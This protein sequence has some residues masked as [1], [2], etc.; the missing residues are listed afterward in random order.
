MKRELG[1]ITGTADLVIEPQV[2]RFAARAYLGAAAGVLALSVAALVGVRE[3]ARIEPMLAAEGQQ[4]RRAVLYE[5]TVGSELRVP[6]EPRTDVLRFVVHAYRRAGDMPLT[7]RKA[8]LSVAVNGERRSRV[9]ELEAYPPGLRSRVTAEDPKLEVGDPM[10]VE[11]DVHDAGVGE[12]VVKLKSI[13]EADG[14]LVRAYRREQLS[15]SEATIRDAALDRLRKDDLARWSWELGWDELTASERATLLQTRW[16]RLGQLRS[17]PSEL[18]GVTVALAPPLPRPEP[19]ARE[20]LLGRVALRGDERIGVVLDRGA[21]LYVISDEGTKLIASARDAS[22][23]A[24][25]FVAQGRLDVGPF[26]GP[27]SIDI[28]SD[29]DVLLE[30]R[31]SSRDAVQWLKFV[32]AYRATPDRPIVVE[33]PDADRL[34]RV[35]LRTPIDRRDVRPA[36]VAVSVSVV[37]VDGKPVTRTF[38][39]DR[40]RSRVDRYDELDP[41]DAPSESATFFVSTPRGSSVRITP[42]DRTPVDVSLGELDT[43]HG[44]EPL[45][46]RK[47]NAPPPTVV[48]PPEES[49]FVAR[50]PSNVGVFDAD[51][52]KTLR[53]ADWYPPAPPP[54]TVAVG[55]VKHN[56]I[57][58][59]DRAGKPFEGISKPFEIE[60]D[61]R[62]PLYLPIV[63]WSDRPTTITI[64]LEGQPTER[65][66]AV[67]EHFTRA[68]TMSVGPDEMHA[69]FVVGEDVP[70]GSLRLRIKPVV[71]LDAP[72]TSDSHAAR[73][74]VHLPWVSRRAFGPRWLA[75]DF[76]E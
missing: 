7:T 70:P 5:L 34:L 14:L 43:T 3:L 52:R 58:R 60:T 23:V 29:R 28:G 54:R 17:G 36:H 76:E 73:V 6:I 69:A 2:R 56:D 66:A 39:A 48:V 25:P 19:G 9:E 46:V 37:P 61:A 65:R 22:G 35:S 26:D 8:V 44:A 42:I 40:A 32:A 68:R 31:T 72:A 13:E 55:H 21:T 71:D 59:V 1:T 50:R 49:P 57:D 18:R 74:L 67:L 27:R 41:V 75:G 64:E 63:A 30:V 24:T 62:R 45:A 10:V 20:Q 33:S 38:A 53:M 12:L 11:I 15:P 47:M 4:A 51:A 16:H